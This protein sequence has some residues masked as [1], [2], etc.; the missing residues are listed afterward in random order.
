MVRESYRKKLAAVNYHSVPS[1]NGKS[2]H[3]GGGR[4]RMYCW[5]LG[6]GHAWRRE[7]T[8]RG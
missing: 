7:T 1:D 3:T 6:S 2:G 8:A 5:M 4:A